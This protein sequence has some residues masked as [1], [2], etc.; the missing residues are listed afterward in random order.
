MGKFPKE[1]L[2]V[3]R[4]NSKVSVKLTDNGKEFLERFCAN[5][6]L[7]HRGS[8]P[9]RPADALELIANYFKANNNTYLEII[10]K[11]GNI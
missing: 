7:M 6:K 3:R 11:G 9:L 10:E 4:M 2:G 5:H 8:T 1:K